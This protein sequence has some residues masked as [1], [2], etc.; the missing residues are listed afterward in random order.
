MHFSDKVAQHCLS[1][2]KIAD[3]A[4]LQRSYC[5]NRARRFAEHFMRNPTDS[6]AIIENYVGSF[7]NRNYGRFI[8]D[9]TFIADTNQS[10][11]GT[12]VNTHIHTE[13]A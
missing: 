3:Y 7:A 9:D 12:E 2:F 11:A 5:A 10:S 13:P 8:E 4:V 6:L 1:D